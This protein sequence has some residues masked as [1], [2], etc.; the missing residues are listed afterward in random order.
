MSHVKFRRDGSAD[1]CVYTHGIDVV[2]R[3]S[4]AHGTAGRTD[5]TG[6][7][8]SVGGCTGI[9]QRRVGGWW[10][11]GG[12]G[13]E[14]R[15][16]LWC[17][18]QLDVSAEARPWWSVILSH[19]A[20]VET[21]SAASASLRMPIAALPVQS[22]LTTTSGQFAP[23]LE[24]PFRRRR[25]HKTVFSRS[26]DWE[27]QRGPSLS[28]EIDAAAEPRTQDP[29]QSISPPTTPANEPGAVET[30][31]LLSTDDFVKMHQGLL[32]P[33]Q[34]STC[35]PPPRPSTPPRTGAH[36]DPAG[37]RAQSRTPGK[38]GKAWQSCCA[39]RPKGPAC[40]AKAPQEDA[41]ARPRRRR[42]SQDGAAE[43]AASPRRAHLPARPSLTRMTQSCD[44]ESSEHV[45]ARRFGR[46]ASPSRSANA[47]E[48]NFLLDATQAL[49]AIAETMREIDFGDVN[50]HAR[51]RK[52]G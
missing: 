14:G 39:A 36:T 29:A 15:E 27:L 8:G 43:R 49:Q 42:A 24:D 5:T 4:D 52:R 50:A 16:T 2:L 18:T 45:R 26:V 20:A 44:W 31:T 34:E 33:E 13:G 17:S 22:S 30:F 6:R 3:P 37:L 41:L 32:G 11:V 51:R 38:G 9:K 21:S 7:G 47:H 35:T 48:P 46:R 40:R 23:S 25:H 1:A 10:R 12:G 28:G 19:V